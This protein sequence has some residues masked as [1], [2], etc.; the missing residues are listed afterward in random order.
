[1]V[2]NPPAMWETWVR[3]LG[4]ENSLEKEMGAH[5]SIFARKIPWTERSLAAYGPWGRREWGMT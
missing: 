5:F 1:M 3:S 4:Q 2:E